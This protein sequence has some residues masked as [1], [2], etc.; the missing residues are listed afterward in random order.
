M[1]RSARIQGRASRRLAP[2][3]PLSAAADGLLVVLLLCAL[4]HFCLT[5]YLKP[6]YLSAGISYVPA[7]AILPLPMLPALGICLGAG[8]ASTVVWSLPRYRWLTAALLLLAG[9]ALLFPYRT[10][11]LQGALALWETLSILFTDNTGFPGYFLLENSLSLSLKEQAIQ[12]LLAG[13]A[14][15]YALLLG[16]A[17]IRI[18]SFWLTFA[19]TLPWLMPAFLAEIVIDW[20]ALTT[21]C[22]CWASML[23]SG[24]SARSNPAGGAR[25]TLL[26]LPA[27]LA[28]IICVS[29][30]FPREGYVQ[31]AW[32]INARDELL[33]LNWFPSEDDPGNL[34]SVLPSG[35]PIP[36]TS[37]LPDTRMDFSTA[38][39]RSYTGR[40]VLQVESSHAGPM[41]LRGESYAH[42]TSSAW[43]RLDEAELALAS[44]IS[45]LLGFWS[46]GEPVSLETVTVTRMDEPGCLLYAPYQPV[47]LNISTQGVNTYQDSA[48]L[49]AQPLEQYTLSYLPVEW[50]L[51]QPMSYSAQVS[52]DYAQLVRETYLEVPDDTAQ[53]LSAWLNL[54]QIELEAEGIAPAGSAVGDY[55]QELNTAA[56]VAQLLAWAADYDLSTPVTPEGEDF[57]VYFLENSHRG[58]CVHFATAATLLL[59][60]QGIPARYVSGYA[61]TI[62]E[63]GTTQVLDSNAHAWVEIYLDG[64]G[65]YPV[66]V[67]PSSPAAEDPEPEATP[68]STPA[69]SLSPS[70]QPEAPPVPTPVP[71]PN[72]T[73]GEQAQGSPLSLQ[74]LWLVPALAVLSAPYLF[75]RLRRRK[76]DRL[77]QDPDHNAAVIDAYGWFQQLERWGGKASPRTEELV[78]KARFSQHTLTAAERDEVVADLRGE[79]LRVGNRLASWRRWLFHI[80]FPSAF[81]SFFHP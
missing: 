80:L 29:L 38:G 32:A 18:R 44:G 28:V 59:R 66:E 74:W 77:L 43:E 76:W 68:S 64:Y 57:A 48:L 40:A 11:L 72:S 46:F 41:Y 12:I 14:V 51:T 54:A 24:L 25:V 71:T 42:Y 21:V 65:W 81:G 60:L 58:Y 7:G 22:A 4:A 1:T 55:A 26:A 53:M 13:A 19:L 49:S 34:P 8:V 52:S 35:D 20:P 67:T 78:R 10:L 17:V 50:G 75:L 27:C 61:L 37:P 69:P 47:G 56:Q 23:L 45:S 15:L 36:N 9:G 2:E 62:P 16:W 6:F 39:P 31:P 79:I 63:E 73:S 70:E 30:V 33:A 5:T 3:T